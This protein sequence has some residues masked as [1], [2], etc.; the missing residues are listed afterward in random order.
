MPATLWIDVEDLFEYA[1]TSPRPSGIQRLAFEIYRVLYERHGDQAHVRFVRHDHLRNSFSIV[2]WDE[3]A[4]LFSDLT[5]ERPQA[6]APTA[7]AAAVADASGEIRPHSPLRQ[8]ARVWA[9]RLPVAFRVRLVDVI[10][11]TQQAVR[12]WGHLF[13]LLGR[14]AFRLPA[15]LG[16]R[17]PSRRPVAMRAGSNVAAARSAARAPEPRQQSF[18]A[19][20]APDDILVTLGSAWSHPDYAAL[21]RSQ[22]ERFGL[23]FALLVYDLI[24]L[25]RP[26]WCDRGLVRLFRAWFESVF[27]L[28]D[29]LFAISRATAADVERYAAEQGIELSVPVIP[30]PIGT[31]FSGA[32][33]AP[34]AVTK[35]LPAPGTYTLIVS[36][37]EARKNH[38]L[39]FRVWRRML[40]QLPFDEVPTLVFAGRVGWLVDDLMR[41]IANTDNLN[42]KLV[43]ILDPTDAELTALYQGCLFTLYPS[44][45]EG[46]GL[47]VTESFAFGKPCVMSNRT[48]LPEAGGGL[49]RSFDPDDLNEAYRIIVETIKDR[50]GLAAWEAQVRREFAPVPWSATVD[51]LLD[52]LA[53][54]HGAP[55]TATVGFGEAA[56]ASARS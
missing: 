38:L 32:S 39:L 48:S 3:V 53:H 11:A 18:A 9:H 12:A 52:G 7:A 22:Q 25:R 35:R 45:F 10:L 16:S 36:T 37:I 41:Q 42:G 5:S 26:E 14:M 28:V 19:L 29:H 8:V 34:A 44:F 49:A 24:P 4:G 46:W 33:T 15:T 1:R 55:E 23:R 43:L 17:L 54:P 40:E 6:E 51:A 21:V 2:A 20:A 50:P 56:P 13:G 27:P 31:G 30:I 47:P